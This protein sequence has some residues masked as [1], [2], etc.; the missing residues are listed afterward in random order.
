MVGSWGKPAGPV[1]AVRVVMAPVKGEEYR[2][3]RCSKVVA[4]GEE[5]LVRG[6]WSE[7]RRGERQE[8]EAISQDVDGCEM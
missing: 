5:E 4:Q 3:E 2:E 1:R 7:I 8:A 6:G